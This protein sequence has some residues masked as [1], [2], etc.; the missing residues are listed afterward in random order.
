MNDLLWHPIIPWPW[1]ISIALLVMAGIGWSLWRGVRS[2]PRAIVLGTLRVLMLAALITMLFQ[3]QQRH[4]EI[5]ILRPQ[6]AVLVDTSES[7]TDPVDAK[8]PRRAQRVHQ[9]FQSK[10][11]EQAKLDFDFRVFSF[12]RGLVEQPP[13]GGKLKFAG[14][15]SNV[16]DAVNQVQERF[17]GQ[18]LAGVLLLSDGL[19]TGGAAKT[20]PI[21]AT[22]PVETFE[23]EKPFAKKQR[24]KKISLVTVDYPPRVVVGW[25]A[26]IRVTLAGSGMSGQTVPVELWREGRK[27]AETQVAFNEDEQT[28]LATFAIAHSKTGP[29]QYEIRVNDPAADKEAHAYPFLIEVMEQG[30]RVL[31]V[32]NTLGFDFKYLR[33]AIASDRNLQLL[34]LIHI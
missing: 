11:V 26:E 30:N 17:R 20:E 24:A 9:W 27:Q 18:P 29:A 19:E 16:L 8:Q 31:Y 15:S 10:A 3:P 22:V 28:R 21:S 5:T 2:K 34:S 23:L 6:L 14:S 4:D 25:D 1:L 32:Q 33:K 7:M 13:G 12:D